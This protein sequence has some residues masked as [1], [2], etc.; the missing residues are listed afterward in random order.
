MAA[1]VA[2]AV[3]VAV[4]AAAPAT[5]AAAA[6]NAGAAAAVVVAI[7]VAVAVAAAAAADVAA[8]AA[9]AAGWFAIKFQYCPGCLSATCVQFPQNDAS[10]YASYLSQTSNLEF[11]E[12]HSVES[13]IAQVKAS[14]PDGHDLQIFATHDDRWFCS[15]CRQRVPEGTKMNGC[16][17]CNFDLCERCVS[18]AK[19]LP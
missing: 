2:V 8:A 16:R 1:G 13:H 6:A 3:A 14:C 7:A 17:A 5:S 12:Q 19:D 15:R 18:S 4:F 11:T 10:A 9:A